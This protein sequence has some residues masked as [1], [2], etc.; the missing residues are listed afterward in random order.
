MREGASDA[1]YP[2]RRGRMPEP[3]NIVASQTEVII[4]TLAEADRAPRLMRA[5]ASVQS[6]GA[7]ALVVING[8][9]FDASVKRSVERLL[10]IRVIHIPQAG[11][12]NAIYVGRCGVA[13]KY[14]A[15]LDD[16]DYLVPGAISVRESFLE[17]HPEI[18]A[19]VANGL[20]EEWGTDARLFKSPADL[21]RIRQ[22]PL[23]ALLTGNWLTPCGGLYRS[24]TVQPD[25]FFDLTQYV[26]WTDL[27][28][29]LIE[30]HRV[31]FLLDSVFVQADTPGS[32]SKHPNQTRFALALHQRM[33]DRPKTPE[34]R[35]LLARRICSFHHRI[36][37]EELAAN[38]RR[39]A[40]HHHLRSLLHAPSTGIRYLAYTRKFLIGKG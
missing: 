31:D 23:A 35:R 30:H 32:L 26:E 18:D 6:Q 10:G 20:R 2:L 33:A 27:A 13:G 9:R 24:E 19:V 21:D 14:F 38:N 17:Q 12:P 39:E 3:S 16:D 11:L 4:P 8:N 1:R 36:A 5:I 28:F 40:L 22:D 15:F 7:A 37:E 25:V 29:R 34:Q